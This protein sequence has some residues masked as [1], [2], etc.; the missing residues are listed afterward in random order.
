MAEPPLAEILA[1]TILRLAK[2]NGPQFP[3]G[4]KRA[5]EIHFR[6]T[7]GD[8]RVAE[9]ETEAA[10]YPVPARSSGYQTPPTSPAQALALRPVVTA[11]Y[12]LF[13]LDCSGALNAAAEANAPFFRILAEPIPGEEAKTNGAAGHCGIEGL[14]HDCPAKF[15]Y[16]AVT[17]L[18][19]K[20]SLIADYVAECSPAGIVTY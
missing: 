17:A 12:A 9:K 15:P 5:L 19:V 7:S 16:D 4:S 13:K 18:R 2:H 14:A 8:L 1:G 6:R 10:G 3:S 20:L 11:G